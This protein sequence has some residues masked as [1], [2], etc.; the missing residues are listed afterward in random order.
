MNPPFNP[1]AG[2]F[3]LPYPIENVTVN[4]MSH[5][6]SYIRLKHLYNRGTDISDTELDEVLVHHEVLRPDERPAHPTGDS[7]HG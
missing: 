6:Y 3:G 2:P 4:T 1:T 5:T 7:P